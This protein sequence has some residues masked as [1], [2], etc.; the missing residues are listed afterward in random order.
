MKTTVVFLLCIIY[1][2]LVRADM[3]DQCSEKAGFSL[4]DL[5]SIYEGK[6]EEEI[7]KLGCFEAC[8]FQK[9][10]M[11]NGNTLNVEKLESRVKELTPDD[12]TGDVHEIIEQCVNQAADDDECMVARKYSDCVI[13][14]IDFLRSK[15]LQELNEN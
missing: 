12:F 2:A 13:E 14:Q 8:I 15:I 6:G 5:K 11:M 4:S 9:L 1:C 10:D 7:K 3:I